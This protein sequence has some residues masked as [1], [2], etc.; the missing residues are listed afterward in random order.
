MYLVLSV[1]R[2]HFVQLD[3]TRARSGHGSVC[4]QNGMSVLYLVTRVNSPCRLRVPSFSFPSFPV[5]PS[6]SLS[7]NVSRVWLSSKYFSLREHPLQHPSTLFL[8]LNLLFTASLIFF[9]SFFS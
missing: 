9:S 6:L 3:T 1:Y 7:L 2:K 8:F 5:P 4:T